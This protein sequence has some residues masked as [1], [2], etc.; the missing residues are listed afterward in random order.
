MLPTVQQTGIASSISVHLDVRG[1]CLNTCTKTDNVAIREYILRTNPPFLIFAI[2]SIHSFK[3]T[4]MMM[5]WFI[6]HQVTTSFFVP[7]SIMAVNMIAFT[8]YTYRDNPFLPTMNIIVSWYLISHYFEHSPDLHDTKLT[9]AQQEQRKL[10]AKVLFWVF[11]CI[12][13]SVLLPVT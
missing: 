7:V 1:F 10:L 6:S 2:I 13:L 5:P 3:T 8:W 9:E 11:I 4:I 12:G